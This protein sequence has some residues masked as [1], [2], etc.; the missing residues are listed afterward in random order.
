MELVNAGKV[1]LV[2]LQSKVFP[3]GQYQQAYEFID[4]NRETTMK[5]LIDVEDDSGVT[6]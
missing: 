6:L 5:V 1:Q 3:F 2:P 4:A